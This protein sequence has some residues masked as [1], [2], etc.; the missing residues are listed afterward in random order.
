MLSTLFYLQ[1]LHQLLSFSPTFPA[2]LWNIMH[3]Y[4]KCWP[5]STDEVTL[6]EP[7]TYQNK[8]KERLKLFIHRAMKLHGGAGVRLYTFLNWH[9]ML[10]D[11]KFYVPVALPPGKKPLL[12]TR[13]E[14]G[15]TPEPVRT[16]WKREKC[17]YLLGI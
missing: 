1:I 16:L 15:W 12:H 3:P 9:Y 6:P 10:V 13:Q 7:N 14:C 5:W 4:F 2:L 17:I 8:H 11:S